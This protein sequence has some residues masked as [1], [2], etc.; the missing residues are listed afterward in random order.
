VEPF[1]NVPRVLGRSRAAPLHLPSS[2]SSH[3]PGVTPPVSIRNSPTGGGIIATLIGVRAELD[4]F[5]DL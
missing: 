1:H 4:G 2:P 3:D 5:A